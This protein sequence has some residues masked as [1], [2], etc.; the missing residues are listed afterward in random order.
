LPISAT[1]T[2][3][4]V[5]GRS[6]AARKRHVQQL[7]FKRGG[8]RK[9]AGRKPTR[10]RAGA[11]H[12]KRD[13]VTGRDVLHVVL[14]A[15]A[16]VGSLR[17]REVYKAVR[18]ATITAAGRAGFRIIQLSIQHTHIH[19]LVE[20]ENTLE[21]AS[22]MHSFKISAARHINTALRVGTRRRRG[23]VFADRYHVVVIRSPRQARH[24][25]AYVLNNFRKHGE[26]R[27][28]LPSTWLVDPFSSG[29]SFT[30]WKEL[31]GQ[32]PWSIPPGYESLV[33]TAPQSW[34]LCAG[35]EQHGA[36]SV[37]EVPSQRARR[38]APRHAP[39]RATRS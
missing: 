5:M 19:M 27:S 28:G 14:R 6:S 18:A 26:D 15:A 24:V 31:E 36:I 8:K 16:D 33:V 30:G 39:P 34:L 25:L 29:I 11:S 13:E 1:V 3:V 4:C 9:G 17:R 37:H 7:L 23:P 21:L 12:K 20:A 35:W 2:I 32:A 38:A 22:G 10:G